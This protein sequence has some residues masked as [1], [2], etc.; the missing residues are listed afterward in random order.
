MA[1]NVALTSSLHATCATFGSDNN[2]KRLEDYN[3]H[4]Q[5]VQNLSFRISIAIGSQ[6]NVKT[7][8]YK[9]SY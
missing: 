4:P 7:Y 5:L 9:I 2:D 1:G 6:K 3:R 8:G